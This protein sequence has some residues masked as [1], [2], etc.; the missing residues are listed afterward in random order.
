MTKLQTAGHTCKNGLSFDC[1]FPSLFLLQLLGC[2]LRHFLRSRSLLD[3]HVER[4]P[5]TLHLDTP[6]V[7]IIVFPLLFRHMG[8]EDPRGIVVRLVRKLH[9]LN[10]LCVLDS[11]VESEV[12]PVNV[13]VLADDG[14]AEG[15]IM[16]FGIEIGC[17]VSIE[18][19]TG[20]MTGSYL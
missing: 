2:H 20:I 14:G 1:L 3:P 12:F 8:H 11:R 7:I 15:E 5:I 4:P 17:S 19:L 13:I 18:R 6:M 16:E 9:L 10:L